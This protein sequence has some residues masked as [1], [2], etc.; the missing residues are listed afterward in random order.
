[1]LNVLEQFELS[2]R[3][4]AKNWGAEWLH[5]LL[6]RNRSTCKLVFGRTRGDRVV[7]RAG[8]EI[9]IVLAHQTRPKAPF[10]EERLSDGDEGR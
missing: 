10:G 2:V 9:G 7:G 4:F 8:D 6:Y 1:M 5:D 3:S